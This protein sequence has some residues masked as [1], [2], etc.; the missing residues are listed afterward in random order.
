MQSIDLAK[1]CR[2]VIVSCRKES[3]RLGHDSNSKVESYSFAKTQI[4]YSAYI[5]KYNICHHQVDMQE[6]QESFPVFY[7]ALFEAEETVL[8]SIVSS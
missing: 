5:E 1:I 7:K 8:V 2:I 4:I 6:P 3:S